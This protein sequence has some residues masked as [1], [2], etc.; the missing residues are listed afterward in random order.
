M[1]LRGLRWETRRELRRETRNLFSVSRAAP[2][3]P[4][5]MPHRQGPRALITPVDGSGKGTRRASRNST[6]KCSADGSNES[7]SEENGANERQVGPSHCRERYETDEVC[8]RPR[9]SPGIWRA[10]GGE[11][12]ARAAEGADAV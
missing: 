10:M 2:P 4:F 7:L 3:N 12:D 1:L 11:T 8:V 9:S 6:K 5:V